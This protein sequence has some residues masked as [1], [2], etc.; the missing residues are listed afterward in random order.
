MLVIISD[1][2]LTDGTTG[3]TIGAGAFEDF[4]DRLTE[5]ALDA[6]QRADGRYEPLAAMDLVLLGDVFDVVRST[7]WS[8]GGAGEDG[9]VRPWDDWQEPRFAAKIERITSKILEANAE[10]LGWLRAFSEEQAITAPADPD[11]PL[12]DRI[13]VPVNIY[14]VTGNHDWYYHLP[15]AAYDAMRQKI[16]EAMGLCHGPE[17]FPH[18]PAESGA[19]MKAYAQHRLFARHGDIYDPFNYIQEEGRN[20]ATLGDAIVVDLI[21]RFPHEVRWRMDHLPGPFLDGLNELA[22]VRPSVMVPLWVDSLLKGSGLDDAESEKVK[23][24]WNELVDEFLETPFVR[25]KDKRFRP[26]I[27]DLLQ[28]TLHLTKRLPFDDIARLATLI[29]EKGPGGNFSFAKHALEEEAFREGMA[30]HVVYGHTHHYEVIPLQRRYEGVRPVNRMYLNSG[31]WHAIHEPTLQG[32]VRRR[33]HQ[34]FANFQVM[35]YLAF[36]ADDERKG[37][38]FETWSGTLGVRG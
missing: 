37:R 25:S 29:W 6:S 23:D 5:L 10:S 36:F 4:R 16:C 34:Q 26:D 12:G 14:Y 31:T 17:P 20:A 22:N 1:L 2:H 13:A 8:D 9:L 3:T 24:I 7:R 32:R 19:L 21:N 15:G 30:D 33:Q 35:T 18:D 28:A 11:D 38:G 27:V